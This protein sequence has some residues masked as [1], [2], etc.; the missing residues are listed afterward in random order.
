MDRRQR[1][2]ESVC[3]MGP[4]SG[5]LREYAAYLVGSY[6]SLC[7]SVNQL[8]S[9]LRYLRSILSHRRV[10]HDKSCTASA[11]EGCFLIAELSLWNEFL[12][13][14]NF[15]LR[16]VSPGRL[17]L[18]C[19]RG[20][21]VPVASNMQRRHSFVLVHWL[22]MEHRCIEFVELCE[23]R[24]SQN[25]FLFRDGLRLS[26]NLRHVKLCYYLLDDY[27]PRDLMDALRST[28][29]TL[30]TLEIVSVRFSSVGVHMLCELIASCE[31]L[32][33]LVFLENWIDVPEIE[34]LMRCCAA[35]RSL[36]KIHVDE[37]FVTIDACYVLADLLSRSAVIDELVVSRCAPGGYGSPY[38]F[39]ALF[40]AIANRCAPLEAFELYNFELN[41]ADLRDLSRALSGRANVKRLTI[42]C[43][44]ASPGLYLSL[45]SVISNN[46]TL[47]EIYVS[48]QLVPSDNFEHIAKAIEGNV[49]LKKLSFSQACLSGDDALPLVH[50]LSVNWTLELLS[51]GTVTQPGLASF[52]KQVSDGDLRSRIEFNCFCAATDDLVACLQ[53][54]PKT[55]HVIFEPSVSL[56]WSQLQ[57]LTR[58]LC[59][60]AYLSSIAVRMNGVIDCSLA[61]LLSTVFASCR[62]LRDAQLSFATETS[63]AVTLLR[64]IAK[65]R[66]L[67]SL[68]FGG[69]TFDYHAATALSDMLRTMRTLNHVTFDAVSPESAVFLMME[70]PRGLE[71]NYTLLSV[72]DYEKRDYEQNAF[73]IRD[74][75]RRNLSLLQHAT[76]FVVPPCC[77]S[78]TA[79]AAFEKVRESRALLANVSTLASLTEAEA[80]EAITRRRRYLDTNFLA[81]AGVVKD[82]VECCR[83]PAGGDR[84][85]QLDDIDFD[86]WMKI[87]SYLS[88]DDVL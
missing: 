19:L 58:G 16:E 85:R 81:L 12:W 43:T 66:S 76:R 73:E 88:I 29:A 54:G 36:R 70:L 24:I 42:M 56:S 68:I 28:V 83:D 17:A 5:R 59:G 34:A 75:L 15:E 51:V 65:S 82:R 57:G 72:N 50:A 38:G 79:A 9:N 77:N 69:W 18:A 80:A 44:A 48:G 35:H 20:R 47:A 49:T 33:A 31:A 25:H 30:D 61:V 45:A 7:P 10:D 40:A 11:T 4:W 8:F 22:L 39:A 14:I 71:T 3:E 37:L 46:A 23:S 62:Y 52:S 63:E 84:T 78:K 27:P 53:Q 13:V 1:S 32:R 86:S 26:R 55:S 60:N 64:G 74:A 2:D 87:R 21:V 67:C 6:P 41:E